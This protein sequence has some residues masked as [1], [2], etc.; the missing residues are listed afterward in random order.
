MEIQEKIGLR[1]KELIR[2]KKTSQEKLAAEAGLD[3]TYVNSVANG[4]RNISIINL[5]KIAKAFNSSLKEFFTSEIF[6]E[7]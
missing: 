1:I 4:R 5:E 3:R 6:K 7:K 2:L